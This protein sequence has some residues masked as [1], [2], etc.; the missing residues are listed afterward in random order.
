[1][2]CPSTTSCGVVG[3]TPGEEDDDGGDKMDWSDDDKRSLIDVSI[4]GKTT[5]DVPAIVTGTE[6][7]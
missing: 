2:N 1:M 4:A 3:G 6:G 7:K 5:A